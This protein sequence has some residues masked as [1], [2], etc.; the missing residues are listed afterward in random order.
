MACFIHINPGMGV[1]NIILNNNAYCVPCSPNAY[2]VVTILLGRF[3]NYPCFMIEK[4]INKIVLCQTKPL[5][6]LQ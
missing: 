2:H 5:D 6:L 4:M 1:E 3:Y